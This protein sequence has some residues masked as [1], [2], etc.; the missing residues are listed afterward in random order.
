MRQPT[1]IPPRRSATIDAH[2]AGHNSGLHPEDEPYIT[3]QKQRYPDNPLDL[4]DDLDYPGERTRM[5]TSARRYYDTRGNQVIQRGNQRFVFHDEPPPRRRRRLH[6]SAIFGIGMTMMVLLF[7]SWTLITNWWT[8]HQLDAT[9][10]FPRT[11]QV[12][13]IVYPG[14]TSDHPSHYIFLNL[15][16]TV[17]I[18]ELPH[19]DS[20]HARIYKGPTLFSDQA[21][22]I[23]VTGEFKVVNSKVEMII[24]I[25]D[26][27]IVYIN[28][29]TQFKPQQ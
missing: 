19:D 27:V 15:N 14:D 22:L 1:P 10:G 8:N 12:D 26:Q 29:G 20:A 25:Q 11:Y 28:D 2:R 7:I 18:I 3:A 24:H 9:Y 21:A 23:P 17:E 16:G 13:A 6:W 4:A 5:P